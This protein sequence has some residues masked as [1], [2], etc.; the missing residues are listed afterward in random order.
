M[1]RVLTE[2]AEQGLEIFGMQNEAKWSWAADSSEQ[3][4]VFPALVLDLAKGT[5]VAANST[6]RSMD[7]G[8]IEVVQ[9]V[10]NRIRFSV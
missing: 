7:G 6:G 9:P 1:G 4:V 5:D 8:R 2:A 3:V 10:R